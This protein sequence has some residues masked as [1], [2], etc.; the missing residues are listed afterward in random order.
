MNRKAGVIV[1]AT[2]QARVIRPLTQADAHAYAQY[3]NLPAVYVP[4]AALPPADDE[5]A[6]RIIGL[7]LQAGTAFA[8]L[9]PEDE[10]VVGHVEVASRIGED[11]APDDTAVELAYVLAPS[12]WHKGLMTRALRAV[13]QQLFTNG[14][15]TVWC[16]V[17]TDNVPSRQLLKRLGFQKVGMQ[18]SP[19]F[20]S[21]SK[22]MQEEWRL[23]KA[24]WQRN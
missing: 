15:R 16:T 20:Q 22:Q 19:T 21:T 18:I 1:V 10:R 12:E 8:V 3:M 11:G 2:K 5:T 13:L 6:A 23:F 24:D 4:A 7:T 9:A 17:Y 14:I